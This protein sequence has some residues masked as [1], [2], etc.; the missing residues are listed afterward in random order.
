MKRLLFININKKNYFINIRYI[1]II[2]AENN[3][4]INIKVGGELFL[5]KPEKTKSIKLNYNI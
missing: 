1:E 3:L 4:N 2:A 5:I